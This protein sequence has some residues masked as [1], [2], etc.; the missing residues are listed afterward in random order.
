MQRIQVSIGKVLKPRGLKGELKVSTQFPMQDIQ[1]V[2]IA[3]KEYR[4]LGASEHAGFAYLKLEGVSTVEQA[5]RLRGLVIDVDRELIKL[6]DDEVLIA[7]LIG[8]DMVSPQGQ[9]LGKVAAIDEHPAGEV[10]VC[11]T[12]SFPYE[13]AFVVETDMTKK[14]IVV[15]DCDIL[16]H[17]D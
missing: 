5:E 17:E 13:D 6:Q 10:I 8:F 15:R 4:V 11:E 3:G 12:F 2:C 7:D 16:T 1:T 9:T 14:R